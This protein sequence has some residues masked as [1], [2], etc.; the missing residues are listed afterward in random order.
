MTARYTDTL[1][2]L[3]LAQDLRGVHIA[4]NWDIAHAALALL[5]AMRISKK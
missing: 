5:E 2:E 1:M 3:A 4:P